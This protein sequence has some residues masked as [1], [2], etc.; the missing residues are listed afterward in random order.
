M[1]VITIS[2]IKSMDGSKSF[3]SQT[4]RY[5]NGSLRTFFSREGQN[6]SRRVYITLASKIPKKIKIFF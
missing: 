4:N 2:D 1:K 3:T 5:K 6:F